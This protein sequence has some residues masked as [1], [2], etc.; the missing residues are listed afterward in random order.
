MCFCGSWNQLVSI[1]ARFIFTIRSEASF[2]QTRDWWAHEEKTCRLEPCAAPPI[3]VLGQ[4]VELYCNHQLEKIE[5]KSKLSTAEKGRDTVKKVMIL[6]S[7]NAV[8]WE[9]PNKCMSSKE[10]R[11]CITLFILSI[12]LNFIQ[13]WGQ[14]TSW[15]AGTWPDN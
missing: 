8:W 7:D 6:P 4:P 13:L 10:V 11:L 2:H 9:R 5:A 12:R 3:E 15:T 14:G 1:S